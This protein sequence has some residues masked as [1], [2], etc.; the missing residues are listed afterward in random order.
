MLTYAE[1]SRSLDGTMQLLRGSRAGLDRL[2]VSLEGFWRSFL[3]I[4]LVAPIYFM[5]VLAERRL[6]LEHSLALP[7]DFD[8]ARFAAAKI[9]GLGLEWLVFPLV[10]AAL[11]RPL[12]VQRSYVPYM[13]AYNWSSVLATALLAPPTLLW[14]L[15]LLGGEVALLSTLVLLAVVLRFRFLLAKVA[16]GVDAT[17]AGLLVALEF[18]LGLLVG[19]IVNALAG[20]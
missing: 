17:T 18:C 14:A 16:L 20:L 9:F 12:S 15:G 6:T 7:E 4:L 2:D 8:D 3:G 10:V 1:I 11:A 5:V 19:K 13:V